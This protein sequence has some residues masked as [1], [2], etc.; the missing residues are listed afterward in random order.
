MSCLSLTRFVVPG[1]SRKGIKTCLDLISVL[2]QFLPPPLLAPYHTQSKEAVIILIKLSNMKP[3]Q[4][5]TTV[6][7]KEYMFLSFVACVVIMY[8]AKVGLLLIFTFIASPSDGLVRSSCSYFLPVP[9]FYLVIYHSTIIQLERQVGK[10][11]L[12]FFCQ[13]QW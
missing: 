2:F 6:L 3:S 7:L 11:C 5:E 4:D 1:T 8:I 12:C 13:W 9:H 10:Q